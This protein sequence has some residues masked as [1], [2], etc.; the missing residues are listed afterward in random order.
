[1]TCY[2]SLQLIEGK[3]CITYYLQ[4][5]WIAVKNNDVRGTRYIAL[6]QTN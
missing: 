2:D 3:L 6:E 5:S 4:I 1:M